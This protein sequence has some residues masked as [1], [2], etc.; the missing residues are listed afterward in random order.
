MLCLL[1]LVLMPALHASLCVP[2]GNAQPIHFTTVLKIESD[3]STTGSMDTWVLSDQSVYRV[4]PNGKVDTFPLQGQL[5]RDAFVVYRNSIFIGTTQG[6]MRFPPNEPDVSLTFTDGVP[7]A[8]EITRP[9]I[10]FASVAFDT[11]LLSSMTNVYAVGKSGKGASRISLPPGRAYGHG[12]YWW[13]T[14]SGVYRLA[15]DLSVSA[16]L[17]VEQT[18]SVPVVVANRLWFASQSS[19]LISVPK[20]APADVVQSIPGR[21]LAVSAAQGADPATAKEVWAATDQALKRIEVIAAPNSPSP[22]LVTDE[23]K[24]GNIKNVLVLKDRLFFSRCARQDAPQGPDQ[25]CVSPSVLEKLLVKGH[26]EQA[27]TRTVAERA[28]AFWMADTEGG[29]LYVPTENAL[30]RYTFASRSAEFFY[31]RPTRFVYQWDGP[32]LLG[33]P[34][35]EQRIAQPAAGAPL[36]DSSGLGDLFAN[37][38]ALEPNAQ[39]SAKFGGAEEFDWYIEPFGKPILPRCNI[40]HHSRAAPERFCPACP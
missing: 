1:L 26:A 3:A 40:A 16:R 36:S 27:E 35:A 21:V 17:T 23:V 25:G 11:V 30:I 4:A 39:L 37:L 19:K 32:L 31:R 9:A 18:A 7:G 10:Y 6:A 5:Q 28:G 2:L 13:V 12:P 20:D 24:E 33:S 22:F 14:E 38:C 8:P 34:L 29:V 15:A